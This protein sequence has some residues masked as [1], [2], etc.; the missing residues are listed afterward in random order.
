MGTT[1]RCQAH[2]R[3]GG[4][5]RTRPCVSLRMTASVCA[6][7]RREGE[8]REQ[9]SAPSVVQPPSRTDDIQAR[10]HRPDPAARL[11]PGKGREC[12]LED[13]ADALGEEVG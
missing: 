1:K 9:R 13:D 6:S 3:T 8:K 5:S 7:S 12:P 4:T 10:P 11:A 2:Q